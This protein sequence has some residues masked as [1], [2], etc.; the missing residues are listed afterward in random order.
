L[1][2]RRKIEA[3]TFR[4]DLFYRL[5]V[6]AIHLPPLRERKDDVPALAYHFLKK[7]SDRIG[8]SVRKISPEAMALLV[9]ETFPGNVRELENAVERAVVFCRD[10]VEARHLGL[11]RSGPSAEAV[12][13][14]EPAHDGGLT[15]T[16]GDLPYREAKA[17]AVAEFERRYFS[18]LRDRTSAN[19]SEA[20]R[21]A[22]LDRSNFR[23]AIKR[24]GVRWHDESD[25]GSPGSR[26]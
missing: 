19:V 9:S 16:M 21:Q 15:S 26:F 20:A 12:R 7:H 14:A 2:L 23:R 6:V 10:T 5:N 25:T 3:G 24:A 11:S 17:L 18:A 4:E 8:R 13:S 1:D 22:G